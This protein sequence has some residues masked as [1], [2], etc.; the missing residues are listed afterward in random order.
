MPGHRLWPGVLF[1]VRFLHNC[2]GELVL[3]TDEHALVAR[4]ASIHLCE[5]VLYPASPNIDLAGVSMCD[6][7]DVQSRLGTDYLLN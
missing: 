5:Q 4:K 2:G 1:G 7:L 3:E 6:E